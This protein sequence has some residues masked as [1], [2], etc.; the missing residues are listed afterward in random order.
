MLIEPYLF[1]A[2]SYGR[3]EA[4]GHRRSTAHSDGFGSL[5]YINY[6]VAD[7]FTV[8]LIPKFSFNEPASRPGSSRVGMGDVSVQAQYRLTQFEE[9]SWIPTTSVNLSESFP[10]GKFDR[11][12]ENTSDGFGNGART[13]TA[14][15][16]SQYFFWMP[17]G[18]ILRTRLN[19]SWS[20]SNHPDVEGIS[21]YGTEAGFR[22]RAE[23]GDGFVANGAWE[24]SVTRN[25]VLAMDATYEHSGNTR[26]SGSNL[27]LS[28]GPLP[29]PG[30]VDIERNFGSSETFSLAPAVE[31]NFNGNVG[32]ILGAKVTLS[33]RNSSALVVPAVAVNIVR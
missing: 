2:I 21:V 22:G 15:V 10:T 14:S 9:G 13:T 12:G 20:F 24:Y 6:G 19:L 26:V 31:Y 1:D 17:N 28:G 11:L 30:T 5:T 25:W 4:N 29:A 16:Y 23:P 7:R 8:G 33:G 32:V 27:P 18:R 3:Y